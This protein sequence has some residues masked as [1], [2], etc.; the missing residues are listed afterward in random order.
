M[1][2]LILY[3]GMDETT[4]RDAG[5]LLLGGKLMRYCVYNVLWLE[6]YAC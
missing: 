4:E 3:F 1:L 2:F 6:G 5:V